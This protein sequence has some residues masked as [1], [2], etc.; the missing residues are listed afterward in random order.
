MLLISGAGIFNLRTAV[1]Q[2]LSK[3]LFRGFVS[4]C[5]LFAFNRNF[6]GLGHVDSRLSNKVQNRQ[7]VDS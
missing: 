7:E 6:S 2:G 1:R 3:E 4:F 5:F